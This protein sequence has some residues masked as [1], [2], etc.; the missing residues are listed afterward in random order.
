[1][2][3]L[4]RLHPHLPALQR[5]NAFRR[6][7]GCRQ[8][9]DGRDSRLHR[10]PPDGLLIEPGIEAVRRIDDQLNA[11]ALDQVHHVGASFFHFVDALHRHA[12]VFEHVGGA[13]RG[14][15]L[16]THVHK[17][18]RDFGHAAACRGR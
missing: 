12:G 15:Q 6:G 18:A 8:R 2:Q 5:R 10:R 9:G 11:L 13:G 16:E 3:L 17:L 7:A 4:Q 14:D 1:M